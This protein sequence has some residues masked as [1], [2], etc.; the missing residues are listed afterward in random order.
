MGIV[1]ILLTLL[2]VVDSLALIGLILIQLPKKDTGGGLAFGGSTSDALFGAGSGNVLTRVTKYAAV[3]FFVLAVGLSL[4]QKSFH[5]RTT[6]TFQKKLS[7]PAPITESQP[8]PEAAPA[9]APANPTPAPAV[10]TN[11]LLSNLPLTTN[12]PAAP[13]APGTNAAPK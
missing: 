4:L 13:A 2:M 8:T 1:I 3:G 7:Q 5:E 12:A 6:S 11:A 10:N 9:P